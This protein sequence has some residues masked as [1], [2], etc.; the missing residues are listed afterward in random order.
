MSM[1]QLWTATWHWHP[2]LLLGGAG[3]LIGYAAALR[4]RL[5]MAALWY[6]LGV[7]VLLFALLS[8]LH[9]LGD[10]YL[11]SAHMAQHL[12]L[13]LVVPPLLLWGVPAAPVE[14]LLR[15]APIGRLA[16]AFGHPLI[17]WWIGI[18]TMWLWHV[19]VLYNAALEYE[20]IHIVEHV[21]FLVAS[22]V[23]WW[24]LCAPPPAARLV[25]LPAL[26]YVFTAM[27]ASSVLGIVLTFAEPGLY[28]AYLRPRDPLHILPL[29]R[30]R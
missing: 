26:L 13:M 23:F 6:G 11:F 22:L 16:R 2:S 10:E 21:C 12:L 1:L 7:L 27:A 8:P 25:A 28:P 24:P 18:G 30:G 9:V 14:R 3:L 20:S 19:P 4:F 5:S 29:L 17:A 15:R